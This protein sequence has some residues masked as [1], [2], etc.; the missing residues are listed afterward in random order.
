MANKPK[1]NDIGTIIILEMQETMATAIEH[2]EETGNGIV[3]LVT[4]SSGA[5]QK[6]MHCTIFEEQLRY[7]TVD[8]DLS[9]ASGD[10]SDI[11]YKVTPK[12]GMGGWEGHGDTVE[13]YVYDTEETPG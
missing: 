2:S 13:V 10:H 5:V 11:P 4:K 9:E 6:W 12:F 7:I 8:G 1:K 3:F